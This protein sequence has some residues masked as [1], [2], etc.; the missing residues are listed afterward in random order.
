M[1]G[2]VRP[3]KIEFHLDQIFGHIKKR[4]CNEE[5][6]EKQLS[7]LVVFRGRDS[8]LFFCLHRNGHLL[9]ACRNA[10][11]HFTV[12]FIVHS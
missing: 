12:Q 6:V 2:E 10:V 4:G 11:V 5:F 8:S 3:R 7:S 1:K 9:A